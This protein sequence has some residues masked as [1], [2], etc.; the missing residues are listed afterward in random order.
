[1]AETEEEPR[2]QIIALCLLTLAAG[3][4]DAL[5]FLKLDEVF[6]SAM[7][8]NTV[9]F[10]I[11]LGQ[12]RTLGAAHS[13]A[14]FAGYAVGIVATSFLLRDDKRSRVMIVTIELLPLA[15]F[16]ALWTL[17]GGPQGGWIFALIILSAIAMG[18]QAALARRLKLPGVMTTII[19]GTLTSMIGSVAERLA[20]RTRP[21]ITP[22][23]RRQALIYS[24]YLIGAT[25]LGATIGSIPNATPFFPLALVG[26][27]VIGLRAGLIEL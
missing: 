4:M 17:L 13:V 7:S 2:R 27:A 6:T 16:A 23:A 10:G 9:F 22:S 14:A 26:A 18:I 1:M 20:T 15:A 8:G 19:T 5:A 24:M 3:T 12:G 25:L 21:A 11:A